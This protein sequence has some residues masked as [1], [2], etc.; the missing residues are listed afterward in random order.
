MDEEDKIK[1]KNEIQT[2]EGK[3]YHC[4]VNLARIPGNPF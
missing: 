2:D 1:I 4:Q 3:L